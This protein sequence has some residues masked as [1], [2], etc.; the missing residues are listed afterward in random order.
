MERN[1]RR[2][3]P[4]LLEIFK[5]HSGAAGLMQDLR[6]VHKDNDSSRELLHPR[7]LRREFKAAC[8]RQDRQMAQAVRELIE[9]WLQEQKAQGRG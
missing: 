7:E 5:Y 1:G 2:K 9:Q 6:D 8:A 4:R 3:P